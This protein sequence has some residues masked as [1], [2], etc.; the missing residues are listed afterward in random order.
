[1]GD[2]QTRQRYVG[3]WGVFVCVN[4]DVNFFLEKKKKTFIKGKKAQKRKYH[5]KARAIQR[6]GSVKNHGYR[7]IMLGKG[8]TGVIPWGL[9][10]GWDLV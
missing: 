9:T 1:M 7:G 2:V 6:L 3:C 8:P 5:E 4:C 10:C